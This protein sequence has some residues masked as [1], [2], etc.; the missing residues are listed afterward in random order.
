MKSL[1]AAIGLLLSAL[2]LLGS[3]SSSDTV[4]PVVSRDSKV[5]RDKALIVMGV[6]FWEMYNDTQDDD[7]I[8]KLHS[9]DLLED[10]GRVNKRLVKKKGTELHEPLHYLSRFRFHFSGPGASEHEFVRF[11]RDTRQYEAIAIHEF[12]PGSVRLREITTE[13]R[14]YEKPSHTRGD[15]RRWAQHWEDYEASFG[16]WDLEAGRVTYM[17]HLTMYFRTERFVLGLITPEELVARI[18]LA[19]IVIEDRFEETKKRLQAEKPWFPVAEMENQS[20]PGKW[21]YLPEVFE[22]F[23]KASPSDAE[24]DRKK[25]IKR[26]IKKY[27]F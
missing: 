13:Q 15:E 4:H 12:V 23:S 5:S 16:S 22:A 3:C 7:L 21:V 19:A 24:E 25:E 9:P 27:F 20:K 17:G 2:L 8:K 14:Y 11:D 26:D 1:T 10:E 6:T 18:E